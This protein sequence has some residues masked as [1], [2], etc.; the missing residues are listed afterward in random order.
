MAINWEGQIRWD[1]GGALQTIMSLQM[2]VCPPHFK[3]TVTETAWETNTNSNTPKAGPQPGL[4]A[5]PW[6][7]GCCCNGKWKRSCWHKDK[8]EE[9]V[10]KA[11][12]GNDRS[13][14]NLGDCHATV[15]RARVFKFSTHM[16]FGLFPG[17]NHR[18][19]YPIMLL[20]ILSSI[21]LSNPA[22]SILQ[23]EK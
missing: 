15:R 8:K 22:V 10:L 7:I 6:F 3:G 21:F 1:L 17:P 13:H 12:S 11:M 14:W 18:S 5:L 9:S 16:L 23:S 20:Q 19:C 2:N 4:H